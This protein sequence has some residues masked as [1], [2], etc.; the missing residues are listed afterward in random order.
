MEFS[1]SVGS[2]VALMIALSMILRKDLQIAC[3][4]QG[5]VVSKVEL[6]AFPPNNRIRDRICSGCCQVPLPCLPKP[7][8]NW[9]TYYLAARMCHRCQDGCKTRCDEIGASVGDQIYA[10][11][12]GLICT[13]CCRAKTAALTPPP[14]PPA[15]VNICRPKEIY[16]AF[17]LSGSRVCSDCTGECGRKCSGMGPVALQQCTEESSLRE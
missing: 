10:V 1:S 4:L 3:Q 9:Q 5:R 8:V 17:Q 6:N 11:F 13:C 14:P 15:S 16:V 12:I 2:F 7:P